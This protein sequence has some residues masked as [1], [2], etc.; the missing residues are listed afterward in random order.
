MTIQVI[1]G[2]HSAIS[3]SVVLNFGLDKD[4]FRPPAVKV[5]PFGFLAK[6]FLFLS[7]SLLHGR[8]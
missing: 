2:E 8:W 7:E 1:P 6:T 5:K 4:S 3:I